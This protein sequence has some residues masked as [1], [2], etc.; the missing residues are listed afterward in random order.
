MSKD[1]P[2]ASDPPEP[3]SHRQSAE[4]NIF[5]Q[6]LHVHLCMAIKE[7][8][9]HDCSYNADCRLFHSRL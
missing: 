5:F 6:C 4:W 2:E 3:V 8:T 1:S 9:M 7:N